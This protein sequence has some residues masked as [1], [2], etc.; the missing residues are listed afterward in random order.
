MDFRDLVGASSAGAWAAK[1]PPGSLL[2]D[3]CR[4]LLIVEH[5]VDP[6]ETGPYAPSIGPR[7]TARDATVVVR[8]C[9]KTGQP[10]AHFLHRVCRTLSEEST[11]GHGAPYSCAR[12][13][14]NGVFPA[15]LFGVVWR[16]RCVL[17]G[18]LTAHR[19]L[20]FSTEIGPRLVELSPH[21]FLPWQ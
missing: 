18:Q 1:F 17:R 13:S 21:C 15:T 7:M 12:S 6:A 19:Q 14:N 8:G 5:V 11:D 10:A 9:H 3:L 16:R 4:R 2:P 20:F